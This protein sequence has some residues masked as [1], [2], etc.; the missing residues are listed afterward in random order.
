M[1]KREMKIELTDRLLESLEALVAIRCMIDT[2]TCLV[3]NIRSIKEDE[4]RLLASPDNLLLEP[5]REAV[6]SIRESLNNLVKELAER[7][8]DV[9]GRST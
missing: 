9:K 1:P 2:T 8:I 4:Y 6:K 7:L 5:Y 3:H